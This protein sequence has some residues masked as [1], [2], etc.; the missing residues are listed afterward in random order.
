MVQAG[1]H[2]VLA[3]RVTVPGATDHSKVKSEAKA[4]LL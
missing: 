4:L 1:G 2:Q 3:K